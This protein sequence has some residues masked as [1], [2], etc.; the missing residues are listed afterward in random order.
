MALETLFITCG[1]TGGHFYPGLTIARAFQKNNGKVLLILSGINSKRQQ[2]IAAEAGIE[3]VALPNM[4]HPCKN[5][6]AFLAGLA[7]GFKET[8]KLIKQY[9]PDA[10]LA[11]GSFAGLPIILASLLA[12]IPLFLHDG[13]AR[14][15][16]ANRHFSWC[17][18]FLASAYPCVNRK[19]V[20][21]KFFVTGMPVRDYL[22]EKCTLKKAPAIEELNDIYNSNLDPELKTILVFGGSL[23]AEV[24]NVNFPAGAVNCKEKGFQ[25]L[26]LCGH[27]KTEVAE[28]IYANADFPVLLLESSE[29]MDLF[30]AAADLAVCRSGGSSL[31]ELA[32]FGVPA[33]LIPLPCAAEKHQNDNANV[34]ASA[35]AAVVF[36]NNDLDAAGAEKIISDFL[37]NPDKWQNMADKMQS[38]ARPD[39]SQELLDLI[40]STLNTK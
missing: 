8:R 17:A 26:H 27:G 13:N 9:D 6:F 21:T 19:K 3:A 20:H 18:K 25:I 22:L 4:P 39:A 40:S 7:G 35:G 30:L 11:M 28:K 36:E 31:A 5:P 2:A 12:K 38:L 14:V 33:I 37:H 15:G 32:I 24:F 23:G 10:L 34:F 29:R 16:R 1:G